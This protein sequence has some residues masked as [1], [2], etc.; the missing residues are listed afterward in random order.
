MCF[1][2]AC[3]AAAAVG[4]VLN[5]A[6]PVP[7]ALIKNIG[8]LPSP[9]NSTI[10]NQGKGL[11]A[12]VEQR[13]VSMACCLCNPVHIN[14]V[15]WSSCQPHLL[16]LVLLQCLCMLICCNPAVAGGNALSQRLRV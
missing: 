13:T 4:A 15:K 3:D 16:L 6:W 2:H 11:H 12:Q 10:R 7:A 14:S 1:C 5:A 8:R 9:L